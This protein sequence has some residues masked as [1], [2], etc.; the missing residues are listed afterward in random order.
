MWN[1][2]FKK[3]EGISSA[4]AEFYKGCL[5][6]ILLGLFLNTLSQIRNGIA[7]WLL[8]FA[9]NVS[10]SNYECCHKP[11]I[12][13]ELN[14]I[15]L[16]QQRASSITTTSIVT[17]KN[18]VSHLRFHWQVGAYPEFLA[19]FCKITKNFLHKI[20]YFLCSLRS[21]KF[22]MKAIICYVRL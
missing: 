9:S 17:Q 20:I 8:W 4:E 16:N 5:P 12:M 10:I 21:E 1:T 7:L 2:A 13:T 22:R 6:Q 15:K 3:F 18:E 14:V 11:V 19:E